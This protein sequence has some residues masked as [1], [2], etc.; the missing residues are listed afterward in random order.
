MAA[1]VE[2]RKFCRSFCITLDAKISAAGVLPMT[3]RKLSLVDPRDQ[4]LTDAAWKNIQPIRGRMLRRLVHLNARP[5]N[6]ATRSRTSRSSFEN[7]FTFSLSAVITPTT[8]SD[9][10]ITGTTISE[11]VLWNVGR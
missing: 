5:I 1:V 4:N 8:R 7:A 2:A 10:L 6:I 9:L 11:S 3:K